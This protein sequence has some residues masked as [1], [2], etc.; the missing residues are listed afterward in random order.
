MQNH[1]RF[2][3]STLP[4]ALQFETLVLHVSYLI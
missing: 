2:L 3:F 4:E 1:I